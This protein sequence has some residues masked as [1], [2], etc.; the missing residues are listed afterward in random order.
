MDEIF[1]S[2]QI[3]GFI[4]TSTHKIQ[5]PVRILNAEATVNELI[6]QTQN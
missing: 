3:S 4:L 2:R 6:D 1:E 5:A